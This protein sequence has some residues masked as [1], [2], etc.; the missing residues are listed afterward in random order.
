MIHNIAERQ[1]QRIPTPR[2]TIPINWDAIRPS[3]VLFADEHDLG[4]REL[5]CLVGAAHGMTNPMIAK[6]LSITVDTVKT[7]L[8]RLFR[9]I[10]VNDRAQ[11]VHWAWQHG[12]FV[13]EAA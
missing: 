2:H 10:D 7:F 3:L 5:Q 13:Q 9:K 1:F 12:L 11:A 4:I 8:A 6:E